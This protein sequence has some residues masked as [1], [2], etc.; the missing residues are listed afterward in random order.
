LLLK[1]TDKKLNL[2]LFSRILK[3]NGDRMAEGQVQDSDFIQLGMDAAAF[4]KLE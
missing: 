2:I 1:L 3:S 4:E